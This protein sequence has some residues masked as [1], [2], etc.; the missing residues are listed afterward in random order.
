M[1]PY[2]DQRYSCCETC[3]HFRDSRIEGRKACGEYAMT[4]TEEKGIAD[5]GCPKY[6]TE[7]QWQIEKRMEEAKKKQKKQNNQTEK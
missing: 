3:H 1:K 5:E 2:Y 7:A 4:F 6:K